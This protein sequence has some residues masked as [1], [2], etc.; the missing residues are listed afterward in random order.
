MVDSFR[1]R[2]II[3]GTKLGGLKAAN[4][5]RRN[6][7]RDYYAVIGAQGGRNG[8]TGGFY[9][10]PELASLAGKLGGRISK[11]VSKLNKSK[12]DING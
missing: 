6:Y 7:G 2:K 1:R 9:K 5:N 10:N 12:G 3:A 8:H 4:T 11:R